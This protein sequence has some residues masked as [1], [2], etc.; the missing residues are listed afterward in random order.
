MSGTQDIAAN[1]I[2]NGNVAFSVTTTA[3]V[4]P[5]PK[6]AGCPNDRWTVVIDD[7]SFA[8][9]TIC[10]YQDTI[11]DGIFNSP[12]PLVAIVLTIGGRHSPGSYVF[13]ER[14]ASMAET[15]RSAPSRSDLLTT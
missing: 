2:K 9:Q 5:T 11:N 1:A 3:P 6:A 4:A 8:Q 13:S 14:F 10:V 7:V 12:S 15:S